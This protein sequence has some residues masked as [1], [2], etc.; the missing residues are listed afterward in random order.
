M[1]FLFF[2]FCPAAFPPSSFPARAGKE[3]KSDGKAQKSSRN[4][5]AEKPEFMYFSLNLPDF[6]GLKA[7]NSQVFF[8]SGLFCF[9][10]IFQLIFSSFR[11]NTNSF[12]CILYTLTFLFF[13]TSLPLT[14]PPFR[15]NMDIIRFFLS[16]GSEI[17]QIKELRE[18]FAQACRSFAAQMKQAAGSYGNREKSKE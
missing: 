10:D 11:G 5:C 6:M 14:F 16:S 2:C 7:K 18:S 15:I 4:S 3:E 8:M 1:L 12:H 9:F 13:S 17:L